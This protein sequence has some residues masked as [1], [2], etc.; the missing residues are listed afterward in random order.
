MTSKTT[1]EMCADTVIQV[2]QR[3]ARAE[4]VGEGLSPTSLNPL[5]SCLVTGLRFRTERQ[6]D[7]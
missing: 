5:R 6:L 4:G 7:D 3:G 1:Q 2:L